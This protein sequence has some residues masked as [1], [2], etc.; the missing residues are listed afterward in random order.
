MMKSEILSRKTL[1][2]FHKLERNNNREWFEAHRDD[3]VKYVKEPMKSLGEILLPMLRE[4]DPLIITDLNRVISRIHRD[5]R[6]SKDKAPYRPHTF[7]AFKRKLE[8]WS[9]TPTYFMQIEADR[10]IFGMGM[11]SAPP[12]TMRRFREK[13]DKSP[14][15]FLKIIEP[16]RKN[17]SME[18]ESEKYKRPIPCE[19][20]DDIVKKI[21]P[22]YQSKSIAVF[23][24]R[25][26]DKTLFSKNF[27]DFLLDR[28]V[29]LK[30]LYDF[31]WDQ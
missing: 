26:P 17:R 22:W 3:Y 30:P 24:Y 9:E 16:I 20:P 14:A 12:A 15:T 25:E 8:G 2:F 6:F 23:G 13:I 21:N 10:Y 4:L 28:F 18:L 27:P 11:Y 5:T 1:D 7:F 31:L 19:F 29:L